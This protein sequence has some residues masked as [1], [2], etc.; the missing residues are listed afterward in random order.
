MPEI[1][2]FSLFTY[3]LIISLTKLNS[4]S[5]DNVKEIIFSAIFILSFQ[6]IIIYQSIWTNLDTINLLCFTIS[7]SAS[8]ARLFIILV[9]IF[10]YIFFYY[11]FYDFR[12][13][14]IKIKYHYLEFILLTLISIEA[15]QLVI[16]CNNLFAIYLLME[17]QSLCYYILPALNR[18]SNI[19]IEATLK[20]FINSSYIS[21]CYLF[22]CTIIYF[23]FGTLNLCEITILLSFLEWNITSNW[24]LALGFF[25]IFCLLFFKL[26][27]IPFH[28]WLI[29]IYEGSTLVVV[30]FF[31]ILTKI[32]VVIL[33]YNLLNYFKYSVIIY[34]YLSIVIQTIC[35]ITILYASFRAITE[36]SLRKL[37]AFSSI[38][39]I[40]YIILILCNN[41]LEATSVAF[42]YLILYTI[43]NLS[44]FSFLAIMRYWVNDE[45]VEI[46]KTLDLANIIKL[47]TFYSIIFSGLIFSIAGIPPFGGFYVKL[48]IFSNLM[49]SDQYFLL[50][51]LIFSSLITCFYYLRMIRNVFFDSNNNQ[52]TKHVFLNKNN[53][54]LLLT[55]IFFLVVLFYFLIFDII[56]TFLILTIK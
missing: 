28:T 41:S 36:I 10:F 40:S 46:K 33:F 8:F 48:A 21:A 9:A 43:T 15:M 50:F 30:A 11:S 32:P 38:V 2:F 44:L 20:Y 47:N 31:G 55:I 54:L 37:I 53:Y 6:G 56:N 7:T 42:N 17:L 45:L 18:K 16:I 35:C 52:N 3:F 26:A 12:S 14:S 1:C 29:D 19:A 49:N 22:G 39:N 5:Q 24:L 51:F 27:F 34:S 13:H 4:F 25:L 23:N